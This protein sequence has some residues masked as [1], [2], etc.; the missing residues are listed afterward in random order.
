MTKLEIRSRLFACLLAALAGFIDAVGF[1]RSGGFFVSF[2]SGNSTRLGVGIVNRL[3]DALVASGLVL[4]FV[5]GVILGSLIGEAARA[6]RAAVVLATVAALL[7]SAAFLD[8]AGRLVPALALLALGM[9]AVNTVFEREGEVRVGVT[10]MTGSLVRVGTGM[11]SAMLGRG[12]RDWPVYLLLWLSFISG[13]LC[14]AIAY[15]PPPNLTL[16][17]GAA[18]SLVLAAVSLRTASE[19]RS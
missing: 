9:G 17:A 10:Y 6:R 18:A 7:A 16:A 5:C 12:G 8:G 3:H 15:G 19:I 14:G 1:I 4:G 13:T 2:M 11:A